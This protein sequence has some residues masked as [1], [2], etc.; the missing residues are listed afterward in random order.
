MSA[1]RR[2]SD[3]DMLVVAELARPHGIRGEVTARLAGVSG[4]DLLSLA[5]KMRRSEGDGLVNVRVTRARP[6]PGWW[7]LELEHVHDRNGAEKLR[8]A[9]LLASR[10]D[11]PAPEPGEWYVADL[12]GLTVRDEAA[13]ELGRLE[14]VL[15]LP[16]NDV[17]VIR[18]ARG[19]VLVPVLED[20]IESVDEEARVMHVRL[21][22]GLLDPEDA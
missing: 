9:V 2:D 22:V 10:K 1:P 16:A 13:G 8:G 11:L 21:P 19:E 20:V 14:E 18:G 12:V 6:R 17:F 4:E 7:I 15:K 3:Q 5:L